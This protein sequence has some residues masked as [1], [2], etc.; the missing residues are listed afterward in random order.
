MPRRLWE[1]T[2]NTKAGQWQ[3]KNHERKKRRPVSGAQSVMACS[4]VNRELP[5]RKE[6]QKG[7][8]ISPFVVIPF[9]RRLRFLRPDAWKLLVDDVE[10]VRPMSP[11]GWNCS[12]N[13]TL[14]S[15]LNQRHWSAGCLEL[16]G[17]T[18]CTPCRILEADTA[19]Q[20]QDLLRQFGS[21][22]GYVAAQGY[23]EQKG[24]G[25][26]RRRRRRKE[27]DTYYH[28]V[29]IVPEDRKLIGR[30]VIQYRTW[31]VSWLGYPQ[32]RFPA[33]RPTNFTDELLSLSVPFPF[34]FSP[35]F[36][37]FP[38]LNVCV[39]SFVTLDTSARS[40]HPR[41]LSLPRFMAR[42]SGSTNGL[43]KTRIV[44]REWLELSQS[45]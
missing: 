2:R 30:F 5:A 36:V 40:L 44:C 7:L 9:A 23:P 16:A 31:L 18:R 24:G 20:S 19:R 12:N 17:C 15:A 28:D 4:F 21:C 27:R 32:A 26:G 14:F 8:S 35:R 34:R 1:S 41:R 13:F 43:I 39:A 25:W 38:R 6:T 10:G 29:S 3:R 45:L 22:T 37:I 42:Q 33:Y 11:G